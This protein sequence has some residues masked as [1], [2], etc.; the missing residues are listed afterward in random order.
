MMFSR[1]LENVESESPPGED[2]SER[3]G[4]L[5]KEPEDVED[6]EDDLEAMMREYREKEKLTVPEMAPAPEKV[7][8]S[9][10]QSSLSFLMDS[11]GGGKKR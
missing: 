1:L 6:E 2:V 10:K 9:E 4:E 8:E 7:E 11:Y 3:P 5:A